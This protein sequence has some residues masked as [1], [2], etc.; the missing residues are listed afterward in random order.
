MCPHEEMGQSSHAKP[1][2]AVPEAATVQP[3]RSTADIGHSCA[4]T[5]PTR[6]DRPVSPSHFKPREVLAP[7]VAVVPIRSRAEC[8]TPDRLHRVSAQAL[9]G[10]GE[11]ALPP[12]TPTTPPRRRENPPLSQAPSR[13]PAVARRS[14]AA[15]HREFEPGALGSHY[16]GTTGGCD[17]RQLTPPRRQREER[18]CP[19]ADLGCAQNW[20]HG[21][22]GC[23]RAVLVSCTRPSASEPRK[24]RC[25]SV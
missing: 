6:V 1:P 23:Q 15:R 8:Q 24:R 13:R 12:S 22:G 18:R 19:T 21:P 5:H 17:R 9:G 20:A 25:S 14:R 10:G 16:T 3:I 2:T 11:A 4:E 7:R